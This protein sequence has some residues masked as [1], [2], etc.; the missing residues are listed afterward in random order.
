M[1]KPKVVK[2]EQ[3]WR[4][5]LTPEQFYVCREKGTERAFTGKYYQHKD[6][7]VYHC[8]CCN[9][10]LFTSDSKY[11]SGCG[12]PSFYEPVNDEAI[13]EYRDT[14]HGMER[15]E[16]TCSACD[17]H[18]GHVFPDGPEPTGLRYC[19]NSVSIDFDKADE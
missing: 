12:W 9:A 6:S 1:E 13:T 17:S 3:E 4:D 10:P 18:I 2:S 5:S 7:G 19:V 14:S 11:D 16:I 8:I 15:I